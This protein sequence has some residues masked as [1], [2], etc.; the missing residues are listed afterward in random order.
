MFL[1][2]H[3]CFFLLLIKTNCPEQGCSSFPRRVPFLRTQPGLLFSLEMNIEIYEKSGAAWLPARNMLHLCLKSI[4]PEIEKPQPPFLFSACQKVFCLVCCTKDSGCFCLS[5]H[6]LYCGTKRLHKD[7]IGEENSS[8][9][10]RLF[11]L[12]ID[13]SSAGYDEGWLRR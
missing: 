6:Y 4:S 2:K 7:S 5:S 3:C 11:W 9:L 1:I 13:A 12:L 8:L 10:R